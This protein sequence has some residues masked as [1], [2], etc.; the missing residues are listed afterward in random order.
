MAGLYVHI[1]FCH[2]KC[3]YCDFYSGLRPAASAVYIDA[4][5]AELHLRRAVITDDFST[6]YIGG[7][8]PSIL[9]VTEMQR[10]VKAIAANTDM[11]RVEEF[12]IEVNPEDVTDELLSAYRA[13]GV[14]R[15]SMGVQSFDNK[16]LTAINR[17]HTATEVLAAIGRLRDGRWNYSIDL[18]FGLPGQTMEMWQADVDRAMKMRPPHI[19]AY[20]LSYEPGTRLYAMLKAGKVTEAPEELADAMQQYFTR[21]AAGNGYIHYEISNYAQP[22]RHSRHNSA[23][24]TMTPYLG[25]GASAHSYDGA[26]RRI[27]PP[28]I[29]GYLAALSAGRIAAQTEEENFDELF[30]DYIITGLRTADGLS[31]AQLKQRF[32]ESFIADLHRDM[33]PLLHA[34]Q[35]QLTDRLAIPERYWLKADAIM[36]DLLRI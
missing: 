36:R 7:G 11:A 35:L 20:L 17:R 21:A 4:V 13:M 3:S 10:L 9:A 27:N 30:N 26:V 29:K 8:T 22:G 31:I 2:S 14:N 6:I 18:M 12:T 19:S 32:P 15:I 34:G 23:Y 33:A 25:L 24:W 1:P 5:I 16:L 28:D